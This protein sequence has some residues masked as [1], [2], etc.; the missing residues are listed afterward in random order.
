MFYGHPVERLCTYQYSLC[1]LVPGLLQNLDDSGS[2]PLESRAKGLSKPT[3]LK[4]SDW[5]S[6]VTYVGL[7]LDLFG[8]D[9][10]FQPYLPLQ[11]L[12]MLKDTKSWL[13]GSTNSI[14]AQQKEIDLLV[15]VSFFLSRIEISLTICR[16]KR[17]FSNSETPNLKEWPV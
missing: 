3:S 13:C 7:P 11:Q 6:M 1:T 4:T 2:P 17:V 9:A 15:N 8:K 5:K 12:D 10:F 16:S 14:V